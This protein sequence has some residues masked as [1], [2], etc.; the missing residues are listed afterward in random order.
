MLA[1]GLSVC[2]VAATIVIEVMVGTRGPERHGVAIC[3]KLISVNFL[4][5]SNM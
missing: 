1:A 4:D 3:T 5:H 2:L